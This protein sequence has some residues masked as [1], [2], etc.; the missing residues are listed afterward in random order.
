MIAS[1][2]QTSLYSARTFYHLAEWHFTEACKQL[3]VPCDIAGCQ[4]DTKQWNVTMLLCTVAYQWKKTVSATYWKSMSPAQLTAE[5]TVMQAACHCRCSTALLLYDTLT[6][7]WREHPVDFGSHV[8]VF[9][10]VYCCV[11]PTAVWIVH[12]SELRARPSS[13]LYF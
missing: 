9:C 1:M 7:Q 12:T 2:Y 8:N 4:I 3:S 13:S 11:T 6:Y 5:M 10:N